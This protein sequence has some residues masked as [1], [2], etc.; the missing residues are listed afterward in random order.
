[1]AYAMIP[2]R[3]SLRAHGGVP[4]CAGTARRA[5]VL[6]IAPDSL[7]APAFD[8]GTA[9]GY[10]VSVS[11]PKRAASGPVAIT[12]RLFPANGPRLFDPHPRHGRGRQPALPP[13]TARS[14][15]HQMNQPQQ[16]I[17]ILGSTGSIGTQ[18]LDVAARH[19]D[20][21]RVVA[22]VAHSSAEALFAQVRAFDPPMAGLSSPRFSMDDVPPELRARRWVFGDDALTAAAALPEADS[23][24]VSVVG[25]CGLQS[26]LTALSHKKRVLLANKEALVAGGALVMRAAAQAGDHM[27]LPVDSEHS[28]IFQC[29]QGA[30]GNPVS[31]IWLTCSGGPF[32]T[33]AKPEI[34]MAT[35]EQALRHPTWAM[36]HKITVD[37]ATLFNKAL[38]MIE[39]RHLFHVEP[40]RIQVLIHPQS[41]VHS[42]VEYADGAVLAQLG[43][44]DMRLPILYAMGYPDRLT[45][46]GAP[47]DPLSL[48]ELTFEPPDPERFP[49]PAAGRGGARGGRRGLLRAER[50]QRGGRAAV[51]DRRGR[52]AHPR[53]PHLHRCGGNA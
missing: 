5:H 9:R 38:E 41:V 36:G 17:A 10:N 1:M 14:I 11:R 18:A 15:P 24:L 20:R 30:A 25:M 21:F 39:A 22:L 43:T 49:Q 35:R 4:V 50:R 44:P 19:A 23:A 45:T 34:D 2:R 26:V 42:A 51:F 32:R 31:R 27:L 33:W 40:E 7:A 52:A 6:H 46:G 8:K 12:R 16:R 47:L 28:A 13:S 3:G 29:L 48:R 53:G 37:S